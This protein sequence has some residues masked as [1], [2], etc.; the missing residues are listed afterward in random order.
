MTLEG[1]GDAVVDEGGEVDG[2]AVLLA[3]TLT[4]L[5][6]L[7]DLLDGAE[8]TVGVGEHVGVELLALTF[9]D[10]PSLEGLEVEADRGYGGLQFV[11]D[12]VDERVVLFVAPDRAGAGERSRPPGPRQQPSHDS[13]VRIAAA[14]PEHVLLRGLLGEGCN[15]FFGLSLILRKRHP[16]ANDL[17]SRLVVFHGSR[18]PWP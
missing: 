17:S 2:D 15:L 9:V 1:D 14:A 4:E 7:E 11:G 12:C 5:A 10:R 16:F 8:E 18:F 13:P 3:M 6:G